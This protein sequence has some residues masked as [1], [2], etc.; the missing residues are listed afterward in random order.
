MC[1]GSTGGAAP[2]NV[3]YDSILGRCLAEGSPNKYYKLA[4]RIDATAHCFV[5]NIA[6]DIDHPSYFTNAT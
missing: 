4:V 1:A 3:Y 2:I 6:N 5:S